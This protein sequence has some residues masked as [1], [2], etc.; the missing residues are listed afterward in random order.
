MNSSD[1]EKKV[2]QEIISK[3]FD[4]QMFMKYLAFVLA[5][6]DMYQSFHWGTSGRDFYEDHLLFERLYNASAEESDSVAEKFVGLCSPNVVCPVKLSSQRCEV[7]KNILEDLEISEGGNSLILRAMYAESCFLKVSEALYDNLE[8][9]EKLTLGLDD[10]LTAVYS[11]HEDNIYLLKQKVI[12]ENINEKDN[13][14]EM[15]EEDSE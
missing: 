2:F 10:M 12:S 8:K 4:E 15:P 5:I 13:H 9:S 14:E 11:D 3:S 1:V 6:R 7:Y